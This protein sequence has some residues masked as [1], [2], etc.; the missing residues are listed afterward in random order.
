[1]LR[2]AAALRPDLVERVYSGRVYPLVSAALSRATA[3]LPFS[4]AECVVAALLVTSIAL[5]G[6]AIAR[7]LRPRLGAVLDAASLASGVYA[8]FL[9]VWGLNYDRE[10][11]ASSAGLDVRPAAPD[12]LAELCRALTLEANA[13]RD[14]LPENAGGVARLAGGTAGALRRVAAAVHGTGGAGAWARPKPV[15]ASILMSYLGISGIY[16]P[17]TGE[18]NVNVDLPQPE[19]PFTA[20]HELAHAR[21]YAREDEANYLAALT[22]RTHP[23]RDVRYSG[24]LLA[25]LYAVSALGPVDPAAARRLR[26]LR[27]DAVARDVAAMAAWSRRYEGAA[28]HVA[29]AVNDAYLRGQGQR[30]GARSYGR[31]VDLLIGE[32]RAAARRAVGFVF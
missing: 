22:C 18:P 23:D 7:R 17:F 26:E 19:I 21:G 29:H 4:V 30:A 5:V 9:V 24:A 6:R 1:M 27:S 14:G 25:S 15:A 8:A 20:A 3:P 13:A 11:Y 2:A 10:P 16:F 28:T 12:E 31:M 32:R